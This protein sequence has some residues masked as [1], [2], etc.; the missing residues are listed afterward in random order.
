MS[1]ENSLIQDKHQIMIEE[2]KEAAK[3]SE[4]NHE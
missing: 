2:I 3:V 1:Q 4:S